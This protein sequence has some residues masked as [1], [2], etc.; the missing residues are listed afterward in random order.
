MPRGKASTPG[1]TS[2]GT[3]S[4][5]RLRHSEEPNQSPLQ[6]LATPK[7]NTRPRVTKAAATAA[8]ASSRIT[9][10][11]AARVTRSNISRQPT[12]EK[13]PEENREIQE[14]NSNDN[15]D[16]DSNDIQETDPNEPQQ[17]IEPSPPSSPLASLHEQSPP[18][19]HQQLSPSP[20]IEA[21]S[22]SDSSNYIRK[23]HEE[24]HNIYTASSGSDSNSDA[25]STP[26]VAPLEE[27]SIAQVRSLS[28]ATPA[29]HEVESI[30][31]QTSPILDT[32]PY[33][34]S[35]AERRRQRE[36]QISAR[37][38]AISNVKIVIPRTRLIVELAH[39]DDPIVD[40]TS[41]DINSN[42]EIRTAL[43]T[44]AFKLTE[45]EKVD[46]LVRQRA[47]LLEME[48]SNAGKLAAKDAEIAKL[49]KQLK[50]VVRKSSDTMT[51]S[52]KGLNENG[53]RPAPINESNDAN[54]QR[55]PRRLRVQR[56]PTGAIQVLDSE[57]P[58]VDNSLRRLIFNQPAPKMPTIDEDDEESQ[59]PATQQSDLIQWSVN[60]AIDNAPT[61]TWYRQRMINF[62]RAER[63]QK[64]IDNGEGD[65][66][67][68]AKQM[69]SQYILIIL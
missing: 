4:S 25:S 41:S 33:H 42:S 45:T 15:Q 62:K 21:D 69:S 6:Q 19:T 59:E 2:A 29:A 61:Q 9:E 57:D 24:E 30:G 56:T 44:L 54:E 28:P 67:S 14:T 51:P 48:E 32:E 64:R 27:H 12:P 36:Q 34:G 40:F 35:Y 17:T 39:F 8:P 37:C 11:Q 63:R 16:I 18:T 3:R 65:Y 60:Y 52:P 58:S 43:Y 10:K 26:A 20:T 53:K 55:S 46:K 1:A 31:V 68:S 66:V 47:Q 22:E 23:T 49:K 50:K 13:T 38:R 5:R 7:R